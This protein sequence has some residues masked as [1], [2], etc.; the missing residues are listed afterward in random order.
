[1]KNI[2]AIIAVALGLGACQQPP[3]P[4]PLPKPVPLPNPLPDIFHTRNKLGP[5]PALTDTADLK[6]W[7]TQLENLVLDPT[8]LAQ[9]ASIATA[10]KDTTGA[11]C[12]SGLIP[13]RGMVDGLLGGLVLPSPPSGT[14]PLPVAFE[15]LRLIKLGVTSSTSGIK[16]QVDAIRVAVNNACSALWVDTNTGIV[17]PLSLFSGS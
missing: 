5:L 17:D 12:F 2:V 11:Q 13:V 3:P 4:L 14:V 16:S 6:D 8:A 9:A 15:E 1:M 10:A 7:F